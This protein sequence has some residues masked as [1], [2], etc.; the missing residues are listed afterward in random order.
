METANSNVVTTTAELDFEPR[1][2][3]QLPQ[4]TQSYATSDTTETK[5]PY[6]GVPRYVWQSLFGLISMIR[7]DWQI[8][9]IAN[10]IFRFRRSLPFPELS[11]AAIRAAQDSDI[12]TTI[13]LRL[14]VLDAADKWLEAAGR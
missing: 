4:V 11:A 6:A 3:L 12:E 8:D 9:R 14:A 5:D 1:L 10:E 2:T 13:D 7:P